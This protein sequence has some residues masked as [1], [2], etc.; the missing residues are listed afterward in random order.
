MD[1]RAAD[2]VGAQFIA[3]FAVIGESPERKIGPEIVETEFYLCATADV[4]GEQ[5]LD[6]F[7]PASRGSEQGAH[8]RE[9]A[10][11][12]GDQFTGQGGGIQMA[13][14]LDPRRR[15]PTR[16]HHMT[17]TALLHTHGFSGAAN[18]R[19]EIKSP[20][21]LQIGHLLIWIIR[22]G[23]VS[24]AAQIGPGDKARLAL[25]LQLR[26]E[27]VALIRPVGGWPAIH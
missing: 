21:V 7:F 3:V 22:E 4:A 15:N 18:A 2:G 25:E 13:D 11:L 17:G 24:A 26:L 10:G 6:E 16:L 27:G 8:T 5:S 20:A 12:W 1:L 14:K 19:H 9:D 23:T